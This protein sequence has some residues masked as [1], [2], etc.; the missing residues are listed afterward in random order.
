[1]LEVDAAINP[2]SDSLLTDVHGRLIGMQSLAYSRVR[3][4]GLAIPLAALR[5]GLPEL[6]AIPVDATV[7]ATPAWDSTQPLIAA[8]HHAGDAVVGHGSNATAIDCRH[9]RPGTA[10]LS[11]RVK[12]FHRDPPGDRARHRRIAERVV[13]EGGTTGFLVSADGIVVTSAA[14]IAERQN[15]GVVITAMPGN[16]GSVQKICA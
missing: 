5:A 15:W 9:L 8:A 2:G 3:W 12:P 10:T 13:P 7:H 6:A 4:L 11:L 16:T 14:L 1:M